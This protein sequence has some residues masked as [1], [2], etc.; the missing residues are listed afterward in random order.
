MDC[1]KIV[2]VKFIYTDIPI[3]LGG[4]QLFIYAQPALEKLDALGILKSD[5]ENA[6]KKG[7]K[8]LCDLEG[9]EIEDIRTI[10]KAAVADSNEMLFIIESYGNMSA[11]DILLKAILKNLYFC[12]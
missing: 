4:Y 12:S 7:S 9:A 2:I 1:L 3:Y 10:D 6:V 8:W 11:K 5:V